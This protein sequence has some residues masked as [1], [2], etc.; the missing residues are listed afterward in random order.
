[1]AIKYLHWNNLIGEFLFNR[2]HE[3]RIVTL[4][5]SEDDLIAIAKNSPFEGL[6]A[7]EDEEI[8]ADYKSAWRLGYPGTFG[9][10]IEK[11]LQEDQKALTYY[12]AGRDV[13]NC[14]GVTVNYHPTLMHLA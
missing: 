11:I 12:K 14:D 4:V 5:L 10:Y 2:D 1:M 6:A 9:N 3:G 13:F 8:I 7:L